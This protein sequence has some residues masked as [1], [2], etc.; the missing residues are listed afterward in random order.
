[1][2]KYTRFIRGRCPYCG[3]NQFYIKDEKTR[4]WELICW[5]CGAGEET[6][7]VRLVDN[8]PVADE[9]RNMLMVMRCTRCG[10]AGEFDLDLIFEPK[11]ERC[12]SCGHQAERAWHYRFCILG[13]FIE[14]MKE[15]QVAEN[16]LPCQDCV[17]LMGT[18]RPSGFAGGFK[19]NGVCRTCDGKKA[20]RGR[21]VAVDPRQAVPAA[22]IAHQ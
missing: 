13:C 5:E 14:W 18:G 16:G 1:M 21:L 19:E 20:V 11:H 10:K 4:P 7:C 3:C 17:D 2:E 8:L 15:I 12:G 9:E 6:S 22:K